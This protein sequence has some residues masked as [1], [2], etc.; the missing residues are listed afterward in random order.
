MDGE[1]RP[2]FA[3]MAW[4]APVA[5]F[6]VA[7][8]LLLVAMTLWELR[9]PTIARRGWLPWRTT[10]GDRLFLALMLLAWVNLAWAG[11]TERDPWGGFALGMLLAALLMRFG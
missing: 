11:V 3:W 8:A 6:F 1:S 7:I 2:L 10:R 5:V 4:T 9:S